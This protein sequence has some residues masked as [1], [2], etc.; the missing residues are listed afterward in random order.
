[1]LMEKLYTYAE[2]SSGIFLWLAIVVASIST[3]G[4]KR[5]QWTKHF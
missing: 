3:M 1:M 5:S 2:R 4:R